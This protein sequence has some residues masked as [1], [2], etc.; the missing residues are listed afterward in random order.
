MQFAGNQ[1]PADME[2]DPRVFK[3]LLNTRG[4]RNS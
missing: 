4:P 2:R 3:L 1:T